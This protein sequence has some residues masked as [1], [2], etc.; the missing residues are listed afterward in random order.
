MSVKHF[1]DYLQNSF[2]EVKR[3]EEINITEA[4]T[5]ISNSCSKGGRF[6]VFGSG[7]SHM[8]AEEIYLRAGGL[9]L[10]KGILPPE[11][12]LHEMPNKSTYLERLPGY[13]E[14]LLQLY[15]VSD[16]DTLMIIS[17]SGRNI[18]P[19]EMALKAKEIG[20][21][22]ITLSSINNNIDS[23]SRHESGQKIQ[24]IADISIDNHTPKGDAGYLVPSLSTPIGAVSTFTGVAIIQA[25]ITQTIENLVNKGFE[26]PVFKSSNLDGADNYNKELFEKYYGYWK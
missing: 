2:D 20:T 24:N 22:I 25:I 12:M 21:K 26:V 10:V 13:A 8:I 18:V 14:S 23:E 17:N 4:A 9:A 5:L 11:L 3:K 15:K 16:N 6:Y 1:F 19:V 7:H